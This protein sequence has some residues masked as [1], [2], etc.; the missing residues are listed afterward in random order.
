MVTT[1]LRRDPITGRHVLVDRAPFRRDEFE[2]EAV[3]L[4]DT[5]PACLLCEGR[6]A[7]AGT[8]I[9]A[10]RDGG[11]ADAPGW[12]VR[13]VPHRHPMLK[14]EGS[15]DIMREGLFEVRDGLGAHEV[16]VET[17]VHGQ[18]L[19]G[20]DADRVWRVLWAWRARV[21]DLKR[22]T[23]F[24]SVVIF[25]NHGRSAGARVDHAHSQL[26]AYPMVPP[27]LGDEVA[28]ASRWYA[29]NGR[30]VFCDLVGQE[31][32]AGQRVVLDEGGVIAMTPFASRVPFEVAIAPRG[33]APRFE[34][35]SDDILKAVAAAFTRVMPAIDWA[36]ERPAYNL[37]LYTAPFEP[38]ADAAF[39][40]RLDILPRVT[41]FSGREWASGMYRNPVAPEE[42]ARVLRQTAGVGV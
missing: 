40:W 35:A 8:E 25:K 15:M 9:L 3:R 32:A 19:Q 34:E 10:W 29:A 5:A 23:R 13:V 39:H 24:A 2:L 36:L 30:C 12:S 38:A 41:R 17:P 4:E 33:H 27:A 6:E 26:A 22:D 16:I 18:P 37:V 11:A 21:Q 31:A 14:V 7:E 20:L 42:A 1:E 28:G